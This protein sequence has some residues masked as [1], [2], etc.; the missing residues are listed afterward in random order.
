MVLRFGPLTVALIRRK[1]DGMVDPPPP[2]DQ[3]ADFIERGRGAQAAVSFELA[4]AELARLGIVLTRRPGEYGVNFRSG[5]ES[6]AQIAGTLD[7]ALEIGRRMAADR[8]ITKPIRRPYQPRTAKAYNRW[9]RKKHMR[10]LRARALR[11]QKKNK[12]ELTADH[13]AEG[14]NPSKKT[15]EIPPA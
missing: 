11:M 15:D 9:L 1:P 14:V 5:A 13:G 12:D 4:A 2:P 6:T 8:P 7:Q 10:K 3:L